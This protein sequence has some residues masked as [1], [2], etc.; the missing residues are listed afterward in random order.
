MINAPLPS[1]FIHRQDISWLWIQLLTILRNYAQTF[2]EMQRY[3]WIILILFCLLCFFSCP[4]CN[5][6]LNLFKQ[7]ERVLFHYN[8]H[9]VPRPTPNG[10]I[11]VFN[12]VCNVVF[13]VEYKFMLY[14]TRSLTSLLYLE[15]HPVHTFICVWPTNMDGKSINICLWLF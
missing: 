15:L 12:K 9:G 10:E 2:D 3:H 6:F 13:R 8:G 11:W 5:L 4:S 14:A 7:E 1:C